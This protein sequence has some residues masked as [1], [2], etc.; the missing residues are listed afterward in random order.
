MLVMPIFIPAVLGLTAIASF[1]LTP[2]DGRGGVEP[3]PVPPGPGPTPPGPG[4]AP[5]PPDPLP[6]VP[7]GVAPVSALVLG[8]GV[9]VRAAASERSAVIGN[10][11]G[12]TRVVIPNTND[13]RAPTAAA[14]E[15]WYPVRLQSGVGGYI[16]AQFLGDFQNV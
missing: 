15:G 12:P 13:L 5:V 9:N 2:R 16:A 11:S 3:G 4:P 8:S 10:V 14:P 1:I 7:P 6:P